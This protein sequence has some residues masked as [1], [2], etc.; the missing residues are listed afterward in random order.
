MSYYIYERYR[1]HRYDS[2]SKFRELLIISETEK[3]NNQN[4]YVRA[5]ILHV[6]RTGN[7][8]ICIIVV[9]NYAFENVHRA[10]H[11]IFG[12]GGLSWDRILP[13]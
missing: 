3:N 11:R 9:R 13:I 2:K 8:Y 7:Y 1:R 4:R 10:G 5:S 6:K 12:P